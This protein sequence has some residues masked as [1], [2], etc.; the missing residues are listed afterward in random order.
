[1]KALLGVQSHFSFHWGTASPAAL[2]ARAEAL[3]FT[4]VGIADHAGLHGLPEIVRLAET[5]PVRPVYGAAFPFLDGRG[6]LAFVETNEGYQ[7][8]EKRRLRDRQGT[9]RPTRRKGGNYS[10]NLAPNRS[11]SE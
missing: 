9:A 7:P 3:G 2:F 10:A 4:H 11:R 1:M 6:V 8:V 5:S